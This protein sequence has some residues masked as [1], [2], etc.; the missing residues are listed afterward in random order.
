MSDALSN[1][2]YSCE[3]IFSRVCLFLR[4]SR[5]LNKAVQSA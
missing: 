3:S 4:F 1:A 2:L 5:F